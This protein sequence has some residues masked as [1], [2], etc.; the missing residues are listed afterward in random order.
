VR[1]LIGAA[2]AT[3]LYLPP[4][5][6]DLNP[7]EIIWSKV[8]RLLHSAAAGMVQALHDA[9]GVAMNA[10]TADDVRGCFRH[11]GYATTSGAPL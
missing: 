3:L 10:A 2:E 5:S 11:C 6:P 9:F 8:K 1:K 7:L 4:C